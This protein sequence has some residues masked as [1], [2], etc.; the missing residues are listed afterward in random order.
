MKKLRSIEEVERALPE[1]KLFWAWLA[2]FWE[3][4][5]HFT[6]TQQVQTYKGR[7]YPKNH[8]V[9]AITNTRIDVLEYIREKLGVG[10]VYRRTSKGSEFIISSIPEAIAV[11]KRLLPFLKFRKDEVQRKLKLLMGI[12]SNFLKRKRLWSKE[13]IEFIKE[14]WRRMTDREIAEKLGRTLS[15]VQLRREKLGLIKTWKGG[16]FRK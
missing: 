13:D 12:W 16:R 3:G 8:V 6:I 9:L 10:R 2:G 11:C 5:G 7:N 4:E 15:A 1:D 14:N